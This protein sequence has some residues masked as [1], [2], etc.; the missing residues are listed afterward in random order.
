MTPR[1]AASRSRPRAGG[2]PRVCAGSARCSA[3]TREHPRG[4]TEP[5]ARPRSPRSGAARTR[6]R[7]TPYPTRPAGHPGGCGRR[8]GG[9]RRTGGGGSGGGRPAAATRPA[10]TATAPLWAPWP[11]TRAHVTRA[12]LIAG[13]RRGRRRGAGA[14]GARGAG[15]GAR[16]RSPRG[17]RP[18]LPPHPAPPPCPP[19]AC[20]PRSLGRGVGGGAV[21]VG[22]APQG[23]V[24][25]C[26]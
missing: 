10:R 21:S 1:A 18:P 24:L 2:A 25:G 13:A 16:P 20:P 15:A 12:Q 3:D 4:R 5:P 14:G 9:G 8:R 23:R 19:H 22:D 17:A 7:G 11:S 26:N 6:C